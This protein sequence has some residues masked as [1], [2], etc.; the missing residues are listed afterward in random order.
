MIR[1]GGLLEPVR[2]AIPFDR[3][4]FFALDHFVRA[5]V[6]LRTTRAHKGFV[7]FALKH[8][9]F[10]NDLTLFGHVL[11]LDTFFGQADGFLVGLVFKEALT[12]LWLHR[13]KALSRTCRSRGSCSANRSPTCREL[14]RKQC[15]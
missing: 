4:S 6:A 2:T 5:G 13:G 15:E 14:H 8:T 11:N 1:V 3:A 12:L 10:R 9:H 7:V